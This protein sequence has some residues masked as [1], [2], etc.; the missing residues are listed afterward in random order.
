MPTDFQEKPLHLLY[1]QKVSQTPYPRQKMHSS[2]GDMLYKAA[3]LQSY[4]VLTLQF[5][6]SC[7][8][9]DLFKHMERTEKEGADEQPDETVSFI[10]ISF[11]MH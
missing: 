11:Y 10:G 6:F 3:A 4:N 5:L 1:P 2:A 9:A 7:G 8:A